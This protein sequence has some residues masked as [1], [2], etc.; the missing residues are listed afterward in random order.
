MACSNEQF[1][2]V[3][4]HANK[5]QSVWSDSAADGQTFT[6]SKMM[7]DFCDHGGA[8]ADHVEP[9]PRCG[10]N[11]T[12]RG[13]DDWLNEILDHIHAD[14]HPGRDHLGLNCASI[15]ARPER[16]RAPQFECADW[17]IKRDG[18]FSDRR[19]SCT[20]THRA[21]GRSRDYW[22]TQELISLVPY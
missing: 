22:F 20:S 5:F 4:R 12:Y 6:R 19:N 3:R 1:G 17:V 2:V 13:T 11:A 15:S 18:L 10:G 21:S 7:T 9:R 8:V 14:R 16:R